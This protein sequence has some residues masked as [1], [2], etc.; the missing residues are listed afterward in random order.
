M[1]QA[2]LC[3]SHSL[4]PGPASGPSL[5]EKSGKTVVDLSIRVIIHPS[6]ECVLEPLKD[7][8]SFP[9]TGIIVG[10]VSD[11]TN[12][13]LGWRDCSLAAA[14]VRTWNA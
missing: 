8:R 12:P 5:P 11:D 14:Q 3:G 4:H 7:D 9:H 10:T 2:K 1:H 6:H 13:L